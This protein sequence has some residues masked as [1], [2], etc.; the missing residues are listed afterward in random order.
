MAEGDSSDASKDEQKSGGGGGNGGGNGLNKFW[1]WYK[2]ELDTKPIFTK[3]YTSAVIF[4]ASDITSQLIS[5]RGTDKPLD[6]LRTSKM[7]LFGFVYN[8]PVLHYWFNILQGL[9]KG[10]ALPAII[11]K[12]LIDQFFM[13]PIYTTC[14][15]T[16]QGVLAGESPQLILARLKRDVFSTVRAGWCYWIPAQAINL[17]FVPPELM[18]LFQNAASYLWNIYLCSLGAK[19]SATEEEAAPKKIEEV[20]EAAEKK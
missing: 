13:S 17:K 14:F 16:F 20:K 7:A 9:I 15:F 10:T 3:S 2:N 18:L 8:G 5:N 1:R 11:G 12:T 4:T 6:C 19:G